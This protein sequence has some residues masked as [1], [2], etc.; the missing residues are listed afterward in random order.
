M[1]KDILKKNIVDL[2]QTGENLKTLRSQ[3]GLT[4]KDLCNILNITINSIYKWESGR[5]VPSID[6]LVFLSS[7]YEVPLDSLV[8]RK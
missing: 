2:E 1:D 6:N 8:A 7:L 5:A 3:K 4:V